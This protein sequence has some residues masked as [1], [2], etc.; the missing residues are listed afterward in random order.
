MT[1]VTDNIDNGKETCPKCK[2]TGEETIQVRVSKT[3]PESSQFRAGY[4]GNGKVQATLFPVEP[5]TFK[6]VT[7]K[8][9]M[10]NGLK[11]MRRVP[12]LR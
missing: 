11:R 9:S 10:C 8:C 7:R 6:T 2:G 3:P 12:S 5:D 4:V 1:T